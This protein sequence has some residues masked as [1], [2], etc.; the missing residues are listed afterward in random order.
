[1]TTATA[2]VPRCI[3]CQ[4]TEHLIEG[5]SA[6]VCR[7][8]VA[9]LGSIVAEPASAPRRILNAL[10]ER[11]GDVVSLVRDKPVRG[12]EDGELRWEWT[13]KWPK[14]EPRSSDPHSSDRG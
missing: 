1:M 7:D 4:T 2:F 14:T 13:D 8:C 10:I 6:I 11:H 9:M 3:R 12:R 5:D